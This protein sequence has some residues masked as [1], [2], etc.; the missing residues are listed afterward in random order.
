MVYLETM[1]STQLHVVFSKLEFC[2]CSFFVM[3]FHFGGTHTAPNSLTLNKPVS[4]VSGNQV[5]FVGS[6]MG[7]AFLAL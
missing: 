3:D 6:W 5:F 2:Y 7:L 1:G 4:F